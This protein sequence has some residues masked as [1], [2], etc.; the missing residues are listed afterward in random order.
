[1]ELAGFHTHLNVRLS[2]ILLFLF[3]FL[4]P[5]PVYRLNGALQLGVEKN[6]C[7]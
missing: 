7:W 2:N 6:P 5:S 1:M 4:F 3:L